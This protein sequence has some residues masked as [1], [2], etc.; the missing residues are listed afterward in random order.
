MRTPFGPRPRDEN[1]D[2]TPPL[3]A[4]VSQAAYLQLATDFASYRHRTEKDLSRARVEAYQVEVRDA[5]GVDAFFEKVV[6]DFGARV[7]C[8]VANA[9][10]NV[11]P[12]P[13]AGFDLE[14]FR[15][16]MDVNLIGAFNILSAAGRQVADGGSIIALTTSLVRVAAPG[17]G[18]YSASKAA[19][20]ALVRAMSREL[21]ARRVRVNAVAPGPVDT[22]LFHEGKSEEVKARSAALSPF[23]RIGQPEEI[24]ELIAFLAS[25]RASWIHGQIV[26][27]NGGLV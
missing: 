18:P 12:G 1:A 9:G 2:A 7:Q 4:T 25:P 23:G 15:R 22:E 17:L 14:T 21:A 20:E 8:V 5:Q 26:Q 3:T 6:K 24:A 16:L 10:I 27:A 19:V 13:V 11:P